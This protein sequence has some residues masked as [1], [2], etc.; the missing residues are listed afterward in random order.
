MADELG[1]TFGSPA[2][3]TRTSSDEFTATTL[4]GSAD[5]SLDYTDDTLGDDAVP[6]H[7]AGSTLHLGGSD[8]AS[9]GAPPAS[10]HLHRPRGPRRQRSGPSGFR[11]GFAGRTAVWHAR[12]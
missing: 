12:D 8:A 7:A 5:T 4:T 2:T 9:R 6:A 1:L 10:I 11:D 3:S